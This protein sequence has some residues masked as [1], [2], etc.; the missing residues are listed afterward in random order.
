MK[1]TKDPWSMAKNPNRLLNKFLNITPKEGLLVAAAM[2]LLKWLYLE[3]LLD[4]D[5]AGLEN[6][7]VN[8]PNGMTVL[9]SMTVVES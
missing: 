7:R 1:K 2:F 4:S 3:S 8:L 5:C 9:I 6:T